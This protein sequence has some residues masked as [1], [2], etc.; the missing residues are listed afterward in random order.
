M[1]NNRA[2]ICLLLTTYLFLAAHV[3]AGTAQ[4]T[5]TACQVFNFQQ[6]S[7]KNIEGHTVE[8]TI[9]R[10][11]SKR[12]IAKVQK[13]LDKLPANPLYTRIE[14]AILCATARGEVEIIKMLFNSPSKNLVNSIEK[15]P[16]EDREVQALLYVASKGSITTTKKMLNA[17]GYDRYVIVAALDYTA[18][19]G[20]M[21]ILKVL[22][23]A[24]DNYGHECGLLE[25]S[26]AL[27]D[28]VTSGN[29]LAAKRLIS[30]LPQLD[31][32][33]TLD[34]VL[35][36]SHEDA[37]KVL[38][39]AIKT[40]GRMNVQDEYGRTALMIVV[41]KIVPM[42]NVKL[43]KVMLN[44]GANISIQDMDGRTALTYAKETGDTEIIEF[45]RSLYRSRTKK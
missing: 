14:P 43:I 5:S 34:S 37:L 36:D 22:V 3:Y 30:F 33:I 19:K 17:I 32:L 20:K 38:L 9:L 24:L 11:A 39:T 4:I 42:V 27:R 8:E 7:S 26:T 44:A 45:L 40:S 13:L 31:V 12:N 28:L 1:N 23:T 10:A 15:Y 2:L 16:E 35:T 6:N 18:I 29:L 41:G 21:A 25:T